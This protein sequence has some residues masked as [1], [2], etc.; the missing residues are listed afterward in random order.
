MSIIKILTNKNNHKFKLNLIGESNITKYI[1]STPGIILTLI[2]SIICTTI[3]ASLI[4][5][6]LSG[7][8]D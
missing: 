4:D 1:G 8:N 2:C 3:F 5:S 7:E 6:M